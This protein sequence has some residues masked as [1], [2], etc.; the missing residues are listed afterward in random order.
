MHLSFPKMAWYL[1]NYV[2][3]LISSNSFEKEEEAKA[4]AEGLSLEDYILKYYTVDNHDGTFSD[5]LST[6]INQI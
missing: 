6:I 1:F 2:P 4:K 3:C 5:E